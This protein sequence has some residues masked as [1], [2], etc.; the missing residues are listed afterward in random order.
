MWQCPQ[1]EREC[2]G[3][4]Q[5]HACGACRNSDVLAYDAFWTKNWKSCF[6][7]VV[8]DGKQ[9]THVAKIS[10]VSELSEIKPLRRGACEFS[11]H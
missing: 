9:F 11:L 1:C 8:D 5:R 7:K 6:I 3:K 2:T 4:N 10:G